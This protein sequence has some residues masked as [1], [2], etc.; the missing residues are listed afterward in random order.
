MLVFVEYLEVFFKKF[1]GVEEQI[2]EIHGARFETPHGIRPVDLSDFWPHVGSVIAHQ[3]R[4]RQVIL[5]A[6][7]P[8]LGCGDTVINGI[9]LV[10]SIIK[11]KLFDN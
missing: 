9:C 4:I 2:I 8:V 11:P 5:P 6:D 3:L 10:N 7:Q 1:I